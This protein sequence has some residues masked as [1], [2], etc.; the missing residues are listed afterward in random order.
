MGVA[1]SSWRFLRYSSA[2]LVWSSFGVN[3]D[4]A[5]EDDRSFII[6][7]GPVMTSS[8]PKATAI[9][10]ER[11]ASAYVTNIMIDEID[12]L[13]SKKVLLISSGHL[14]IGHDVWCYIVIIMILL[15]VVCTTTSKQASLVDSCRARARNGAQLSVTPI[16]Y[17]QGRIGPVPGF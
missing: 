10:A 7:C 15:F 13:V 2:L 14:L 8:S 3:D 9:G 16:V 1:H 6:C 4:D 11:A 12:W 5:D 17:S